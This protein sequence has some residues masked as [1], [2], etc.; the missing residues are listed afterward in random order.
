VSR[1]ALDAYETTRRERRARYAV[2]LDTHIERMTWTTDRLAAHQREA[3][4]ALLAHARDAS[5]FHAARL[6]GID[7]ATFEPEDLRSLPVMTKAEMMADF[8]AVVTDRRV[9]RQAVE[10]HLAGMSDRPDFLFDEYT[11]LATGGTSGVRGVFVY[12]GDA[13]VDYLAACSRRAMRAMRALAP[14]PPGGVP[15]AFVTAA[16]PVHATHALGAIV[17]GEGISAGLVPVT[18]P[19]PEIVERLNRL[20]PLAVLGY[21]SALDVLAAEQ[22]AGRL[23][24]APFA[25][26]ASSETL[27]REV[28]ERITATFGVPVGNQFGSTEGLLGVSEPGDD[29]IVFA[30][31]LAIAELVDDDGEP[32][33]AGCPSARVLVTNLF[34]HTQPLIRYELADRFVRLPD[35][36]DHGHLR[37]TVEGRAADLLR[38]DRVA[39]HPHAI[40]SVLVRHAA[41]HEYQVRQTPHGIDVQVVATTRVDTDGLADRL[42]GALEQAGLTEPVV[43]VGTVPAPAR[44]PLTGKAR[45]FVPMGT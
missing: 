3:L 42:A 22:R 5:P 34:N 31:D 23:A 15:M 9:S 33:P 13:I 37:A 28:R 40:R 11:C 25:I 43:R 39:V 14:L 8:D 41:V 30:S 24:I 17:S 4:R 21:P 16:S 20:Q 32:V 2:V 12:E 29:A 6:A 45:R 19:V 7:P 27:A 10:D 38:W 36:D 35:A 26:T 18:L 1:A 44:D